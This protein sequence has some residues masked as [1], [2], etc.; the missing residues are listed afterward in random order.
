MFCRDCILLALHPSIF[1]CF[2]ARGHAET[3]RPSAPRH[4]LQL[5]QRDTT[6]TQPV[7]DVSVGCRPS[8]A[9]HTRSHS[10]LLAYYLADFKT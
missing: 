10:A 1:C 4:L 3:L 7:Q 6:E 5:F 2:S 8:G 9:S